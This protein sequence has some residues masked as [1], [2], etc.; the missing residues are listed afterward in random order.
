[1]T[2]NRDFSKSEKDDF[3]LNVAPF[4]VDNTVKVVILFDDNCQICGWCI[5]HE[6]KKNGGR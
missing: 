1:M 3:R 4:L 5:S 6:T 2:I